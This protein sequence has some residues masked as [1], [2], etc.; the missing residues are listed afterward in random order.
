MMMMMMK[1]KYLPEPVGNTDLLRVFQNIVFFIFQQC[2]LM[3]HVHAHT[4]DSFSIWESS[5]TNGSLRPDHIS[6]LDETYDSSSPVLGSTTAYNVPPTTEP[7]EA[8]FRVLRPLG[9]QPHQTASTA[10][11]LER[12]QASTEDS[13]GGRKL[14]NDVGNLKRNKTKETKHLSTSFPVNGSSDGTNDLA[15]DETLGK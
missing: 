6:I 11:F 13:G 15:G 7:S 8:V 12:C 3:R 4:K 5:V 2:D 9:G 1:I 14:E 10:T